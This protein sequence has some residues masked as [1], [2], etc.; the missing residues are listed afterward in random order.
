MY[1]T[2]YTISTLLARTASIASTFLYTCRVKFTLEQGEQRY[3][4]TLSLTPSLDGQRHAPA[5]LPPGNTRYPLYRR[6]GGPV[7]TV[8]KISLPPGF[9]PR[10][11]QPVASCYT[12]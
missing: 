10:T 5:A 6:V 3:I 9:D 4:S 12:D 1:S 2:K 8:R 7:W 11:I